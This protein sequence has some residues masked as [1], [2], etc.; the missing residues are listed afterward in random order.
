MLLA[1]IVDACIVGDI[2]LALYVGISS[3][4]RM[5][6]K[7]G[8]VYCQYLRTQR[9]YLNAQIAERVLLMDIESKEGLQSKLELTSGRRE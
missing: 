3:Y 7:K 9:A 8:E 5:L 2:M 1:I 6:T 4:K